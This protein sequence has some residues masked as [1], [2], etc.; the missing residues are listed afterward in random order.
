MEKNTQGAPTQQLSPWNA[1]DDLKPTLT[2]LKQF[3]PCTST[4]SPTPG[5][6][7]PHHDR[8]AT[9]NRRLNDGTRNQK[10]LCDGCY[11]PF[12]LD[13]FT[14]RTARFAVLRELSNTGMSNSPVTR[15]RWSVPSSKRCCFHHEER[16]LVNEDCR[17]N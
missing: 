10:V 4:D 2:A 1:A 11:T 3:I 9:T 7:K 15:R 8:R 14:T 12:Q 13:T 6:W 17:S 16:A 5:A